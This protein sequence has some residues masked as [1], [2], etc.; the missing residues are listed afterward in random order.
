[1][2]R[3]APGLTLF[4]N[5]SFIHSENNSYARCFLLLINPTDTR[6]R[7][8]ATGAFAVGH[9][10]IRF[11]L[12][13]DERFCTANSRADFACE[14]RAASGLRDLETDHFA[15]PV[16]HGQLANRTCWTEL[17]IP[18]AEEGGEWRIQVPICANRDLSSSV[19]KPIL[20]SAPRAHA[21]IEG[22]GRPY[23]VTVSLFNRGP[24]GCGH[25]PSGRVES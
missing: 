6:S 10:A 9:E 2:P 23:L 24:I 21:V 1:M 16:H 5:E 7:P 11:S 15:R 20:Q 8:K 4:L 14:R 13:T 17:A 22:G 12:L 19:V 25:R 18:A 3:S